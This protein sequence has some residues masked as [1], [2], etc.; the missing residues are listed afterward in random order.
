MRLDRGELANLGGL[1]GA[2]LP[3]ARIDVEKN[4]M[5]RAEMFFNFR[6]QLSCGKACAGPN[7][8]PLPRA[9]PAPV[10]DG[11]CLRA[12]DDDCIFRQQIELRFVVLS[13][14]QPV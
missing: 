12:R 14:R 6:L 13:Q 10:S 11:D 4:T 8:A 1:P 7:P 9:D 3:P 2:W 5:P